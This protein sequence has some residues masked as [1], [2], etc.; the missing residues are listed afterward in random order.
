[1]VASARRQLPVRLD[2]LS[3]SPTLVGAP[4]ARTPLMRTVL[5]LADR[6]FHDPAIASMW[7]DHSRRRFLAVAALSSAGL[8]LPGWARGP[9]APPPRIAVVGGGL[10]GLTC[11][12]RLAQAGYVSRVYEAADRLGGRCWSLR[13]A[14]DEDQLVERGGELIDSGAHRD[15]SARTGAGSG[16]GQP[17]SGRGPGH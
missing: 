3:L 4:V 13:S 15:P 12:Y 11:A 17:L 10:A 6:A 2:L 9:L 1:M 8:A 5:R 14:F 7:P 16:P